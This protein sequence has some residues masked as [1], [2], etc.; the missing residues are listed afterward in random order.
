M[1]DTPM[2]ERRRARDLVGKTIVGKTGR[3]FGRVGDIRFEPRTGELIDII[4]ANPT[5]YA[6]SVIVSGKEG[7][8]KVPFSAVISIGDFVIISEE[9]IV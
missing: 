9:D 2:G 6:R 3:K 8:I 1:V 4:V 5:D 7:T